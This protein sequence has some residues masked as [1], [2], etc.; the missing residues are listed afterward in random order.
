MFYASTWGKT[1]S[2]QQIEGPRNLPVSVL[3]HLEPVSSGWHYFN[4]LC[5]GNPEHFMPSLLLIC[6]RIS[7]AINAFGALLFSS[8][9]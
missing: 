3:L 9:D 6:D 1:G 7:R 4:D 8:R 2:D 5:P